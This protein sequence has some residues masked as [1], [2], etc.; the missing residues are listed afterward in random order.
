[1]Q[2]AASYTCGKYYPHASI[3]IIHIFPLSGC[4][5]DNPTKKWYVISCLY[6]IATLYRLYT[7][8]TNKHTPPK[9][10]WSSSSPCTTIMSTLS[11]PATSLICYT[12]IYQQLA[13]WR[14]PYH[15]GMWTVI[16]IHS[17]T[18]HSSYCDYVYRNML[19][20]VSTCFPNHLPCMLSL[21]II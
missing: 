18:G 6:S 7:A 2:M 14:S 3:I 10:F 20:H 9:P 5:I 11:L 8:H 19:W 13:T 17:Y 4:I 12:T 21:Y 1:M 15:A 16:H